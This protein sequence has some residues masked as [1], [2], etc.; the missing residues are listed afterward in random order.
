MNKLEEEVQGRESRGGGRP[1]TGAGM[2]G[3]SPA[4]AWGLST[5]G[6]NPGDLKER[7][8]GRSRQQPRL[9][10]DSHSHHMCRAHS[11]CA[12]HCPEL[13]GLAQ[14]PP[15]RTACDVGARDGIGN[16]GLVLRG[17]CSF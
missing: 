4:G 13:G 15:A 2:T 5:Q 17:S 10:D 1:S 12:R 9:T 7:E 11:V 14:Q 6:R 16:W 8:D 3:A